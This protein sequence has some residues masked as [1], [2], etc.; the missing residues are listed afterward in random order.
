MDE[1]SEVATL[2]YDRDRYYHL[3]NDLRVGLTD[4][5]LTGQIEPSVQHALLQHHLMAA[6]ERCGESNHDNE[7]HEC[8]PEALAVRSW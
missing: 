3:W 5:V 8:S 4:L 2:R 1:A 6:A 7:D